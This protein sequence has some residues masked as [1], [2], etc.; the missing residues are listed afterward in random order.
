VT[1][2]GPVIMAVI[3]PVTMFVLV[4]VIV[5]HAGSPTL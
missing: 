1:A 5:R 4:V 2:G 3:M